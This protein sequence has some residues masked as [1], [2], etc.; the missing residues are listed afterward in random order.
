M[1]LSVSKSMHSCGCLIVFFRSKME[2]REVKKPVASLKISAM[3]AVLTMMLT[4]KG[5]LVVRAVSR[6]IG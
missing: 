6:D 4:T 3:A 2:V 1:P 5:M